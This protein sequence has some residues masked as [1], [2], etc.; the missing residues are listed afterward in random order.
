MSL[1]A[2]D[3]AGECTTGDLRLDGGPNDRHGRVE[4]CFE[5]AWG[6]VCDDDWDDTNAQ[7]ICRQLGF[8]AQG[9]DINRQFPCY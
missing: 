9:N 8:S 6:T 4:L 3:P 1:V 2:A 7:V 5:G